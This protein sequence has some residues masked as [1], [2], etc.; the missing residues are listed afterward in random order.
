DLQQHQIRHTSVRVNVELPYARRVAG[1]ARSERVL[2]RASI[3][4]GEHQQDQG[5]RPLVQSEL[6]P[7]DEGREGHGDSGEPDPN[8]P[9]ARVPETVAGALALP[10]RQDHPLRLTSPGIGLA[11][12]KEELV[13]WVKTL[14]SAA[15]YATLIVT[16]G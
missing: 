8:T 6:H 16:F 13:A 2:A 7:E 4:S 10:V 12:V 5:D 3:A 9:A 11:Q 14:I 1:A 15:V